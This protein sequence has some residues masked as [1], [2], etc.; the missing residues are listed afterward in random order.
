VSEKARSRGKL[1]RHSGKEIGENPYK[2]ELEV[3]Y[4]CA[5]WEEADRELRLGDFT[6]ARNTY[7]LL[8]PK[9]PFRK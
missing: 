3:R 4:W 7:S 9:N 1:D 8:N 2:R 5:G 6:D